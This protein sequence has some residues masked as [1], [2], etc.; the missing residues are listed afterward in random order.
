MKQ[1]SRNVWKTDDGRFYVR[2]TQRTPGNRRLQVARTFP[3]RASAEQFVREW[4][5][6][7]AY[8]AAGLRAPLSTV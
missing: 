4:D 3:D 8:R 6:A 7:R 5:V 2:V 1:V